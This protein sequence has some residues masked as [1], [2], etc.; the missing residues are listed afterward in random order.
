M[1]VSVRAASSAD[2]DAIADFNVAMAIETEGKPID[3]TLL[4]N[5]VARLMAQ[6]AYGR[7]LVA[8][9]DAPDGQTRVAGCLMLTYEWSDWRDGLF[10]WIQSVYVSTDF[11]RRGVFSALYREVER[12]AEEDTD[13]R[14]LRLYVERD[15]HAAQT[16]Y[17]SLGMEE[18]HYLLYASAE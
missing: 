16:T 4:R 14:G 12:L 3:R 6:P 18:T 13:C 7:Y 9:C 10:W 17:K 15:N 1:T 5:G 11:R 2:I 8:E